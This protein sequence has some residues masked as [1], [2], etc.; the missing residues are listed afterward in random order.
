MIL[1]GVLTLRIYAPPD[2]P[3]TE[4]DTDGKPANNEVSMSETVW[5][6]SENCCGKEARLVGVLPAMIGVSV[7]VNSIRSALFA[8]TMCV[9]IVPNLGSSEVPVKSLKGI[10]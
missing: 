4:N 8:P 5:P 2:G 7:T 1:L 6:G 10:G 3:F 9:L